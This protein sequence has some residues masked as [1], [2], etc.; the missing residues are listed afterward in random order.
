MMIND[1]HESVNT[2]ESDRLV[3]GKRLTHQFESLPSCIEY[4]I[5]LM[6]RYYLTLDYTKESR[7]Q[8]TTIQSGIKNTFKALRVL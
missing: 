6:I 3:S 8:E 4:G 2:R 5:F 7:S 1:R